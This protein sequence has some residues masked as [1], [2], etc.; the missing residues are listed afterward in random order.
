VIYLILGSVAGL[1][2]CGAIYALVPRKASAAEILLALDAQRSSVTAP[3]PAAAGWRAG[4][5]AHL[6]SALVA[7][8][9]HL[10][11]T[12][13]D[14]ALLGRDLESM[15]AT[16]I[17]LA[18]LGMILSPCF[19]ALAY[20]VGL[21]LSLQT[22]LWGSLLLASVLFFAPDQEVHSQAKRA[23]AD[24]RRVVGAYLDLI[25]LSLEG[26]RGV[27]EALAAA[28]H[29]GHGPALERLSHAVASAR[30]TG[31]TPW[32]GLGRLG[33]QIGVEELVELAAMLENVADQGA[34]I[35]DTLRERA[36]TGRA[37]RAAAVE[38][39]AG[40]QTQSLLLA[41]MLLALG[42]LIYLL[43]PAM[44]KLVGL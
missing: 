5:G 32:A 28:A 23:R 42:F 15:L 7:R 13:R 4:L 29:V 11:S 25:S 16:K 12:R 19:W 34:K 22:P 24:F 31:I 18:A 39:S 26:G 27:P 37:R 33:E 38:E 3:Q 8:G 36:A 10:R 35:K 43:Y 14:L 40:G 6:A 44:S 41:Q 2:L 30:L 17:L 1:A 21:R 9:I 20:L